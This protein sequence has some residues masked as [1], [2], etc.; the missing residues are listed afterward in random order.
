MLQAGIARENVHAVS[1][2]I[3]RLSLNDNNLDRFILFMRQ[4]VQ[5]LAEL[6]LAKVEEMCH[7]EQVGQSSK[8]YLKIVNLMG[9]FFEMV[10]SFKSYPADKEKHEHV[11]ADFRKIVELDS[12]QL[13]CETAAKHLFKSHNP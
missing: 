6:S 5:Q 11:M 2:I 1:R 4:L 13:L 9:I 12:L 3:M 7:A 10:V 8:D